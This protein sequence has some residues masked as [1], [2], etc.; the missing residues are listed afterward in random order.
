M[1]TA[2]IRNPRVV[3]MPDL[4]KCEHKNFA[5]FA[6]FAEIPGTSSRADRNGLRL[7]CTVFKVVQRFL[8]HLMK[9]V[10][11]NYAK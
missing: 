10:A 5:C 4:A 2:G 6:H 3:V 9:A 8:L 7:S 1:R 11:S